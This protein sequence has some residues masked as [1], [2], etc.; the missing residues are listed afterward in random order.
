MARSYEELMG[1]IGRAMFFRP[2]RKRVRD[3]WSREAS[4]ALLIGGV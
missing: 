3:L 4:P 2:E 1:A